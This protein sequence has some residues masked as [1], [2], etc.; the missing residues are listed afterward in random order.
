MRKG[1][2]DLLNFSLIREKI[3][4]KSV[5]SRYLE[6]GFGYVR[7]SQFMETTSTD[8]TRALD[9]F[10]K[11]SGGSDKFQ[12]LILDLRNNPGGLLTQAV[13]VSDLFLEE[14]VIVYTDGRVPAQKQK[15]FAHSAGT[16]PS[17]PLVVIVNGG[18]ASASEI[19]AGALK[20]HGRALILGTQTFGK[21]SVQTVNP[22]P[23]GGALQLTTALY[24]TKSGRSIQAE[25]VIPDIEMEE[26]N[27]VDESLKEENAPI[28]EKIPRRSIREK[29]LPGAFLNPLEKTQNKANQR[30]EKEATRTKPDEK[31][32]KR[33]SASDKLAEK[34][35]EQLLNDDLLIKRALELLQSFELFEVR[36]GEEKVEPKEE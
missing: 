30:K 26:P 12:G 31:Q 14:G 18:S 3:Q 19:V 34:S 7:V 35:V 13:Q 29:D 2:N 16:E 25:G 24:F 22:L 15:F 5:S 10:K 4:I 9:S 17:Y 36:R 1:V 21:G 11:K 28:K 8:L 27:I 32:E 20:D 33:K 6:N 23:N